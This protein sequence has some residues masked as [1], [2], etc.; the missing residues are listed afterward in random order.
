M[1]E[2]EKAKLAESDVLNRE[3]RDKNASLEERVQDLS[4]ENER[5]EE[6]ILRYKNEIRGLGQDLGMRSQRFTE[7]Q[8]QL[9]ECQDQMNQM[10]RQI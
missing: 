1:L 6:S 2:S 7:L 5:M 8:N 3:L 9:E 4:E 10:M